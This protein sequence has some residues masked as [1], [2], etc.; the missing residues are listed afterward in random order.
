VIFREIA[1]SEQDYEYLRQ[2]LSRRALGFQLSFPHY[3]AMR[4]VVEAYEGSS[5][6]IEVEAE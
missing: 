4:R 3:E 1:L 5:T 6:V 2:A